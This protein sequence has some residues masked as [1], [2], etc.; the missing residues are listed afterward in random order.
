[1]GNL[2]ARLHTPRKAIPRLSVPKGAVAIGGEQTGIYPQESP[3]GWNII[4]RTPIQL[5]DP[6]KSPPTA[7]L[8]GNFVRFIEISMSEFNEIEELVKIGQ[9]E[10]KTRTCD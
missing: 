1:L 6:K 9:Y 8:P 4:G 10:I 5:F 7:F 3:G 2:N